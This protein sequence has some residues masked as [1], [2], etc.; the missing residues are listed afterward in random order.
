M[1][2]LYMSLTMQMQD[3]DLLVLDGGKL[4]ELHQQDFKVLS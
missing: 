2:N 1:V 3:L 4:V